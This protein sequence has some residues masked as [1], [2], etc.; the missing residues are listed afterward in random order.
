MLFKREVNRPPSKAAHDLARFEAGLGALRK[1]LHGEDR[2]LH[3]V[4]AIHD[5]DLELAGRFGQRRARR[6][7]R[8]AHGGRRAAEEPLDVGLELG[9]RHV[10][11]GDHGQ[12][13]RHVAL[14][15]KRLEV[16]DGQLFHVGNAARDRRARARPEQAAQGRERRQATRLLAFGAQAVEPFAFDAREV[17][18]R[19][20]PA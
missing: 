7:D 2:R 4:F 12:V 19:E 6:G 8:R 15:V 1:R 18:A 17:S 3:R 9:E 13:R 11:D 14:P 10:A 16:G 20:T 5:Q